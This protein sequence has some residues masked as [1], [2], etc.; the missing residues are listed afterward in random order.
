M[1]AKLTDFDFSKFLEEDRDTSL[2]TTNVGTA[3][4]KAP[5]FFLRNEQK[6]INYHRNVD[7]FALGLTYLAMAQENKGL[8]P[9]IE[10]PNEDSELHQPVGRLIAER[11]K[12][13]KKPLDVV[14]V[15][16]LQQS[17]PLRS[18]IRRMTCHV[19]NEEYLLL[20]WWRIS[21]TNFT[22]LPQLCGIFML[23]KC[24]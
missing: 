4:F 20:R 22:T 13:K 17:M 7:V 15:F 14:P 1:V 3:A 18:L 10:T 9:K 12:Y 23:L 5:E 16:S 2:M 11:I 19:P 6:K 8:V 24:R 21:E